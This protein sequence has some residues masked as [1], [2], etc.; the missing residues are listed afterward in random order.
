MIQQLLFGCIWVSALGFY[1]TCISAPINLRSTTA[2][3][4]GVFDY[5]VRPGNTLQGISALALVHELAVQQ[6]VSSC[7][8]WSAFERVILGHEGLAMRVDAGREQTLR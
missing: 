7:I 2:V 6:G 3:V 1:P 4:G 5:M 8:D